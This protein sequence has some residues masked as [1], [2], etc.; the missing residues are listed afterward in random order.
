[1]EP[2]ES[3]VV[4]ERGDLRIKMDALGNFMTTKAYGEMLEQDQNDLLKQ[5]KIMNEYLN[6]L[7][8]RIIRF[9]S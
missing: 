7:T 6:V 8:R 9:N 5:F 1:M 4:D 2:H 3:R